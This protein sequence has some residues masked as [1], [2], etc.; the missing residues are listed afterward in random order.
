MPKENQ[1]ICD[2]V[3]LCKHDGECGHAIPHDAQG[4]GCELSVGGT[5][6]IC[7]QGKMKSQCTPV[8][9][10][11]YMYVEHERCTKCNGHGRIK[12]EKWHEIEGEV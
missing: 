6:L 9:N 1:V 4:A 8:V 11:R 2:S 5:S 10:G 3:H 12:T 7:K